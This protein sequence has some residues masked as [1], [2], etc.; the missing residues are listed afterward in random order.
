MPLHVRYIVTKALV[1]SVEREVGVIGPHHTLALGINDRKIKAS[2]QS[3]GVKGGVDNLPLGEA[4]G[5][6]GDTERAP[7]SERLKASDGL[8]SYS[9]I[10]LTRRYGERQGIKDQLL[11]IN[12]VF[13]C[14]A[15]YFLGYLYTAVRRL[16]NSR[17]VHS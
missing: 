11:W 15:D 1:V 7:I 14:L 16:G 12:A 10:I 2:K 6:V 5:D 17:L 4:E 3:R 9:R 13:L 8:E